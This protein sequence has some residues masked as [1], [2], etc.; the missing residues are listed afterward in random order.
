MD[1]RFEADVIG[2][3]HAL[4]DVRHQGLDIGS[5]G[6]TDIHNKIGMDRG[7][8]GSPAARTLQSQ[9]LNE[10]PRRRAWRI[11]KNGPGIGL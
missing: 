7:D 9:F 4:A 8:H 2:C 10:T 5:R 11:F 3:L 6:M 1:F